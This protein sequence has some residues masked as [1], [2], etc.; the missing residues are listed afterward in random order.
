[1][2]Q[3]VEEKEEKDAISLNIFASD[4]THIMVTNN[5]I[6]LTH[7]FLFCKFSKKKKRKSP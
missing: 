3:M 4:S 7:L 6:F 2:K 5:E 1:M